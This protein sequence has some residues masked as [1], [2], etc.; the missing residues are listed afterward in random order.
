MAVEGDVNWWDKNYVQTMQEGNDLHEQHNNHDAACKPAPQRE[1]SVSFIWATS[2]VKSTVLSGFT[3]RSGNE[4]VSH[5]D[6]M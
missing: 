2:T 6:K 3:V 1:A 4:Y 5:G